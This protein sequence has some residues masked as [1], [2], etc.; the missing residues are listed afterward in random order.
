MKAALTMLCMLTL[1]WQSEPQASHYSTCPEK[2]AVLDTGYVGADPSDL[3][4]YAKVRVQPQIPKSC[5]CEGKVQVEVF[6]QHGRVFCAH[7]L[8]GHPVLQEAAVKAAMQ[9]RFSK[10]R[11]PFKDNIS[12]VLTFDV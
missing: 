9:W 12:G 6:V 4:K 2:M 11:D 8:D 1:S 7:A 3:L 5:R 10:R